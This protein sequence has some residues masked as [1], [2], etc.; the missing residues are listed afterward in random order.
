MVIPTISQS[1]I[2]NPQSPIP[3]PRSIIDHMIQGNDRQTRMIDS[4]LEI[5]STEVEGIIPNPRSPIPKIV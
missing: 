2:P 1:P 4:L 5:H 3:D